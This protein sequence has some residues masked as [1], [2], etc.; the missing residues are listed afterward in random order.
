M[1]KFS[2]N[3]K[4]QREN[5]GVNEKTT[6][7]GNKM[8]ENINNTESEADYASVE[9]PLNMHRTASDETTLVPEVP[10]NN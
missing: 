9:D 10:K 1:L 4:I 6:N 5:E 2:D 7:D 3:A 8:S